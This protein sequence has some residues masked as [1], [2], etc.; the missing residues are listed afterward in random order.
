MYEG[1][2]VC[3]PT[4]EGCALPHAILRHDLAGRVLTEYLMKI[5][6]VCWYSCT[7]AAEREIVRDIND[8]LC[9]IALDFDTEMKAASE[10]SDKEE[11]Y[12]P[13]DGSFIFVGSERFRCP[14]VLFQPS[15]LGKEASEIHDSALQ[16]IM[17]CDVGLGKDL[18]A[19]DVLSGGTTMFAGSGERMLKNHEDQVCR[20]ARKEVLC[21]DWW[22]YPYVF[23]HIPA[24]VDFGK[25]VR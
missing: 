18:Y 10:N 17:K 7:K 12:E 13:P 8:K 16:P 19:N 6:T 3:V 15:I 14:E 4:D 24:D 22:L 23:E 20:A 2:F 11:T 25:R 5:P 9:Y 1:R 21:V